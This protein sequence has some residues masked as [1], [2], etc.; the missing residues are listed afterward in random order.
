MPLVKE[1]GEALPLCV[2]EATARRRDLA[3]ALEM[4]SVV[5]GAESGKGGY[6]MEFCCRAAEEGRG[7]LD[8][9]RLWLEREAVRSGER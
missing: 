5:S 2:D 3:E 1:H 4:E 7:D 6:A 8:K 9:A